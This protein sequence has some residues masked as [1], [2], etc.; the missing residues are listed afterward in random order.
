[1]ASRVIGILALAADV[2]MGLRR[3]IFNRLAV[4]SLAA[5]LCGCETPSDPAPSTAPVDLITNATSKA[6][7]TTHWHVDFGTQA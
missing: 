5:A 2:N 1:M 3:V 7:H 6:S 4:L